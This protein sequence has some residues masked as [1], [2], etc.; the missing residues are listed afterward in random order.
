M[1]MKGAARVIRLLDRASHLVPICVGLGFV[2][3]GGGKQRIV[4]G[5]VAE[6]GPSRHSAA[7]A[8]DVRGMP[9]QRHV[10]YIEE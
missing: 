5:G 9:S 1:R 8:C 7:S 3:Y 2:L 10:L 4:P 6:P